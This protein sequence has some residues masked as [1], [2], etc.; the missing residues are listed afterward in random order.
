VCTFEPIFLR[1]YVC[2]YVCIYACIH[3]HTY[4]LFIMHL[5]YIVQRRS[6]SHGHVPLLPTDAKKIIRSNK[7]LWHK[8]GYI[9]SVQIFCFKEAIYFR[10]QAF[11]FDFVFMQ[12]V[13]LR[14]DRSRSMVSHHDKRLSSPFLFSYSDIVIVTRIIAHIGT[15]IVYSFFS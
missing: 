15:L 11:Q 9:G 2:M 4:P 7:S 13:F 12:V 8:R 5:S 1:C 6:N 10:T 14:S 3:I